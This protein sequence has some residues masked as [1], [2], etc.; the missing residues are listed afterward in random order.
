MKK[1]FLLLVL[2]F[3]TV[4]LFSEELLGFWGVDFGSDKETVDKMMVERGWKKSNSTSEEIE[5]KQK[6]GK[7]AGLNVDTISFSF[8]DNCFTKVTIQAGGKLEQLKNVLLALVEKYDLSLLKENTITSGPLPIYS[9][10]YFST[11]MNMLGLNYSYYQDDCAAQ[12]IFMDT[13]SNYKK[14]Q[15]EKAKIYDSMKDDL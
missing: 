9:H 11:N 1:L 5:Y 6:D 14:I 15:E 10:G 13:M 8:T 4:T 2:L 3:S 12:F 7:Y